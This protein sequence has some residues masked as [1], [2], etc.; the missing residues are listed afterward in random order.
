MQMSCS[1]SPVGFI[2]LSIL[3]PE[4]LHAAAVAAAKSPVKTMQVKSRD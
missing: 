2:F 1:H 4:N 3:L